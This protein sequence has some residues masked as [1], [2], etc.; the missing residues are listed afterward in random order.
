MSASLC[1]S[2]QRSPCFFSSLSLTV[3]AKVV[4]RHD[5]MVLTLRP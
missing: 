4:L 1:E 5:S 2:S 3:Y